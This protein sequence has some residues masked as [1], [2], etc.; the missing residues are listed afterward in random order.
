MDEPEKG[1]P[2]TPCMDVYNANIQSYGSL[3]NLKLII[4]VRGDLHNKYKTWSPT[5]SMRDFKY[6]LADAVKNKSRVNQ[7]GFIGG[8]L[9]AKVNNR[10]FVKFY[11]RYAEYFQNTLVILEYP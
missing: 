2:V 8:F 7:L 11:S 4:V 9:H 10:I 6:L 5:A 3:E 1:Y